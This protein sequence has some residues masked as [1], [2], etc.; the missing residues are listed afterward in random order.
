MADREFVTR[1]LSR[2]LG[3]LA[4]PERIGIVEALR[5]GE[6][7]VN[8]LQTLLG[9]AHSRVSQNLGLLRSNRIVSERREGRHVF[10]HLVQPE[11]A[12]WLLEGLTFLEREVEMQDEL[13]SAVGRAREEWRGPAS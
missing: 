1:E 4:H 7:D 6:L 8:S 12:G 13:R 10:Y 11:M 9:I 3:V 5:N 2:L